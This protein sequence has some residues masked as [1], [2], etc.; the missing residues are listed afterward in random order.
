MTS[1]I[2]NSPSVYDQSNWY[3]IYPNGPYWIVPDFVYPYNPPLT[4]PQPFKL[5]NSGTG[6]T[7]PILPI[8]IPEIEILVNKN[9]IKKTRRHEFEELGT[10][11]TQTDFVYLNEGEFSIEIF[12]PNSEV[13]GAKFKLNDK[14]ISSS[15]L[16]IYPGQ[17]IVL[18]RHIDS[19]DKLKFTVYTV[20]KNKLIE[21]AIKKNGDLE[22]EFYREYQ[23]PQPYIC[24]G[25]FG[26]TA[27]NNIYYVNSLTGTNTN[28]GTTTTVANNNVTF[29]ASN[30][31][32]ASDFQKSLKTEKETGIIE[33]GSP[34]NQDLTYINKTFEANS[35][36]R[37]YFKM[38][39][40][41]E[42]PIEAKDLVVHCTS[43]GH[44]TKR[45]HKF[46]SNCG[47]KIE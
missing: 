43:C 31:N 6:L 42:K 40:M 22:I 33:K 19:K 16:I 1:I 41:S 46:C 2:N 23:L 29:T 14:Y 36:F 44:K 47:T 37:K 7:L 35:F 11:K 28:Y 26:S 8:K 4:N 24:S 32:V 12:N 15:H 30:S 38:F 18:D 34:S 27:G 3:T 25:S 13:I 39:P 9:R 45:H 5:Y 17:R 10:L 20:Y 21:E